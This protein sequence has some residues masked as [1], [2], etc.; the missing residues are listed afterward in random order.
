MIK[1]L[2][3]IAAV[4]ALILIF[5]LMRIYQ[6]SS[7]IKGRHVGKASEKDNR[8]QGNMMLLFMG[9]FFLFFIWVFFK[10]KGYTWEAFPAASDVG[11]TADNV[12]AFNWVIIFI[13]FF[14]TEG[15]LFYFGFKYKKTKKNPTAFFYPHNDKLELL[16]TVVPSIALA[17]IIIYG[18]SLWGKITGTPDPHSMKIQ[19]YAKQFDYTIRYA[20]QDNILGKSD[21][22]LVN[23]ADNPLGMDTSDPHGWDDIIVRSTFHIP[24]NTPILFECNS[25]DVMHGVYMPYQREQ[26]NAVPG[27]TTEIHFIP[28]ITTAEMRKIRHDTAFNYVILCNRVCGS[29][30]FNMHILFVVDSKADY[31]K[32]LAKQ[33]PF[34][35][36]NATALTAKL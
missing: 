34:L 20:G 21:Y 35:H 28:T 4:L 3:Y 14:I 7:E 13:V 9:A 2:V 30:H 27:M 23:D 6:L 26:I 25:R 33:H 31:Q 18:L 5:Q 1:L 22:R 16:W 17:V 10:Y 29:G 15:M 24:V 19:I 32:W 8:R 12:F 11:H 36:H